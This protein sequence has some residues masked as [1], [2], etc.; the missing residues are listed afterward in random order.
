MLGFLGHMNGIK[1]I[2]DTKIID[3][4]PGNVKWVTNTGL[5]DGHFPKSFYVLQCYIS[6]ETA[7]S[8]NL[9]NGTHSEIA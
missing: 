6:Y 7:V 2:I 4:S 5:N 9:A 1:E 8:L 3:T